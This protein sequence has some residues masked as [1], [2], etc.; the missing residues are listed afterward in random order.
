MDKQKWLEDSLQKIDNMSSSE[1]KAAVNKACETKGSDMN[2]YAERDAMALDKAGNHYCRHVVAMTK[3]GL[4]SKSDIAAE[5]G[6]R[7]A[8]I[9]ELEELCGEAYQ[10]VASLAYKAGIFE[11][12]E[13]VG[14]VL[15][16]LSECKFVHTDILP[17][18]I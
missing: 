11:T 10:V 17:F 5:L 8:R 14:K 4:H 16:N 2:Q 1:F 9:A 18:T 3:E 15:D 7:D 13:Q 6:F 12:S